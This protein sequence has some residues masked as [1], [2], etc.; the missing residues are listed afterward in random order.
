MDT[1]VE[2]LFPLDPGPG[3]DVRD[4]GLDL[5]FD[6]GAANRSE[7]RLPAAEGGGFEGGGVE[8]FGVGALDGGLLFTGV[9]LPDLPT[10]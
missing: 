7:T 1:L 5:G 8:D 10:M 4:T 2:L 9:V 6:F 3:V